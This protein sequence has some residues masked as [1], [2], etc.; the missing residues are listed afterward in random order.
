MT[1]TGILIRSGVP[2]TGSKK[3]LTH[4]MTMIIP[5]PEGTGLMENSILTHQ[6]TT[7]I[8][9]I[10]VEIFILLAEAI[11]DDKQSPESH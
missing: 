10:Q 9:H 4:L 1:E 3:R 2:D 8:H 5:F 11:S 7:L 6:E